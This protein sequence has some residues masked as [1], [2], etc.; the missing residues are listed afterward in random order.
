MLFCP[1]ST[2][3]RIPWRVPSQPSP[4]RS[5]SLR[6]IQRRASRL[7][8]ALL[9][10]R[11]S[12]IYVSVALKLVYAADTHVLGVHCGNSII[13][14]VAGSRGLT[15]GHR[16]WMRSRKA[17]LLCHAW[18]LSAHFESVFEKVLRVCGGCI[19]GLEVEVAGLTY[20]LTLCFFLMWSET[21][22]ILVKIS[23]QSPDPGYYDAGLHLLMYLRREVN[24]FLRNFNGHRKSN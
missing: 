17:R 11:K 16:H 3:S 6:G 7:A 8:D 4:L 22:L 10:I 14:Q 24:R 19:A 23:C 18:E 21:L 12:A 5:H 15:I 13:A 20:L 1:P 2:P 9:A